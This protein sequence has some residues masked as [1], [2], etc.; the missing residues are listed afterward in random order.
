MKHLTTDI[1]VILWRDNE[2]FSIVRGDKIFYFPS[3]SF[4]IIIILSYIF[5]K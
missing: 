1:Y 3:F 4:I 2:L 5:V